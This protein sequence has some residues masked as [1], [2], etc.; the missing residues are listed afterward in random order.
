MPPGA[1]GE[2][3]DR[4]PQLALGRRRRQQ[5][6]D[7]GEAQMRPPLVDT[8]TSFLLRHD[9]YSSAIRSAPTVESAAALAGDEHPVRIPA[10]PSSSVPAASGDGSDEA[11]QR[12]EA[13]GGVTGEAFEQRGRQ[14]VVID[15]R[16][17]RGASDLPERRRREAVAPPYP[18]ALD[19]AAID[20][21]DVGQLLAS[22]PCVAPCRMIAMSTTMAAR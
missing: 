17:E 11:Q 18:P 15:R 12:D 7:N 10:K 5:L 22:A 19:R 3:L 14:T 16:H 20:A 6:S 1:L 21:D 4:G 8:R 13:I 9:R 2:R